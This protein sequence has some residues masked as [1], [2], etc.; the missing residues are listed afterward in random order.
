MAVSRARLPPRARRRASACGHMARRAF[1][2]RAAQQGV[3]LAGGGRPSR[4]A[5]A[6]LGG[7]EGHRLVSL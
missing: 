3:A 1:R 5:F 6:V 4:T 2:A 7:A